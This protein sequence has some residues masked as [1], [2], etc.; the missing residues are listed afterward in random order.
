M[1]SFAR[2]SILLSTA[3]LLFGGI[4][5]GQ[6]APAKPKSTQARGAASEA[7]NAPAPGMVLPSPSKDGPVASSITASLDVDQAVDAIQTKTFDV[8][9]KLTAEIEQRLSSSSTRL[10]GAKA[11]TSGLTEEGKM[12]FTN[13]VN[14]SEKRRADLQASLTAAR[15][16]KE[17][18]WE[19]A[20]A[21]LAADYA[22]YAESVAR[23]E[24]GLT[25]TLP[26]PKDASK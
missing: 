5:F 9:E 24:I 26:P 23:A 11:Q 20:R 6:S 25:K 19:G 14:D 17:T 16:A 18:S 8:R 7:K 2:Y 12:Q 13:A 1:K 4:A 10:A 22:R 21:Q 3:S 15:N